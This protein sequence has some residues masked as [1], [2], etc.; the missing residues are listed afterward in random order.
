M[1]IIIGILGILALYAI[2]V[3][4]YWIRFRRVDV[5]IPSLPTQFDGFTILHLSDLHGRVGAFLRSSVRHAMEQADVIA[6]TGDLYAVT[7]RDIRVAAYLN[8]LDRARLFYVSG[9]HDYRHGLLRTSP[10]DPGS[11]LLDNRAI[12]LARGEAG[13]WFAGIPDLVKGNPALAVVLNQIDTKE[14]AI[15]LSHRPDAWIKDG[16]QRFQLILS[17]HTHGGQVRFPW[18]GALVRHNKL[19]GRYVS[20]ILSEEGHPT[21]VTSK[22]LGMSE[23]PVRFLSRPEVLEICLRTAPSIG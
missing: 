22:G 11:C 5:Q 14:P 16:I 18:I 6:L 7:L 8:A 2:A 4:P 9:N 17:G 12:R 13:I 1:R 10:W 23:L 21:L 3:E 20:G 19:P 15:L